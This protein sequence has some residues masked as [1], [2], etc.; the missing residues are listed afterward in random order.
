MARA[1]KMSTNQDWRHDPGI[2]A[3]TLEGGLGGV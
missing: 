3:P 2:L 1:R